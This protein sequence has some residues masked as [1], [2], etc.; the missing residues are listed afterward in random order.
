MG[1]FS[2]YSFALTVRPKQP[3]LVPG[4]LDRLQAALLR[5]APEWSSRVHIASL[6]V[7]PVKTA[8]AM[9]VPGS[10]AAALWSHLPGGVHARAGVGTDLTSEHEAEARVGGADRGCYLTLRF[11]E[12]LQ[13]KRPTNWRGDL[14]MIETTKPEITGDPVATW[15]ERLFR[16]ICDEMAPRWARASSHGERGARLRRYGPDSFGR[17]LDWLTYFGTTESAGLDLAAAASLSGLDCSNVAGGHLLRLGPAPSARNYGTYMRLLEATEAALGKDRVAQLSDLDRR[18]R[19]EYPPA[20]AALPEPESVPKPLVSKDRWGREVVHGGRY[21]R[22]R[23][24]G[25]RYSEPGG[26]LDGFEVEKCEFDNVSIGVDVLEP[27]MAA[28]MRRFDPS[29]VSHE[30]DS[31]PVV[32][33]NCVLTRCRTWQAYLSYVLVEDSIVDGL[34]GSLRMTSQV[35]LK[36]VVIRGPIDSIDIRHPRQ[37]MG[38]EPLIALH[39][40][41]YAT[42]D[43]AL[44]ISDARFARCD[45]SGVPGRLVRRDPKTQ[46][47]VTRA[48]A[49]AAPWQE[50]AEGEWKVGIERML[51]AEAESTVFVACS[52][53]DSFSETLAVFQ[54]LREAGIAEP[55]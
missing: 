37:V 38:P 10:L 5:G 25:I 2:S 1:G 40:A 4:E 24:T 27:R 36:H 46:I 17:H 29:F 15:I 26:V 22:M 47:L 49:L 32:V 50:V 48:R 44:D 23:F 31:Q 28:R 18:T 14:I 16:A 55:D 45:I 53:E 43:W 39:D 54:R 19:A 12:S 7:W 41:H 13:P 30:Y 20:V 52:R 35:L 34:S 42:V 21:Q 33:R 11:G 51:K 8:V 3:L 6:G 9:R